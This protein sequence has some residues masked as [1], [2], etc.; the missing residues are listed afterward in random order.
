[1]STLYKTMFFC[2]HVHRL[3]LAEFFALTFLSPFDSTSLSKFSKA[4]NVFDVLTFY[5]S[6]TFISFCTALG[7]Q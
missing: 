4:A 2:N 6:S 3:S 5:C 7:P 1:M